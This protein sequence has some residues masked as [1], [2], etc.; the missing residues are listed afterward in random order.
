MLTT[1]ASSRSSEETD[2][3]QNT[4]HRRNRRLR[5]ATVTAL[6]MVGLWA[7]VAPAEAAPHGIGAG[8]NKPKYN[9]WQVKWFYSCTDEGNFKADKA[10]IVMF[11][12]GG[13]RVKGFHFKYRIVP[14]D[15]EGQPIPWA[16]WSANTA[17]SFDQGT[18]QTTWMTAGPQGQSWNPAADWDLEVKLKYP[19]SKRTAWRYKYRVAL[20]E[21]TCS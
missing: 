6:C 11:S 20:T 5:R 1:R 14:G 8:V 9:D 10:K 7:P 4:S 3:S 12:T 18:V 19:R 15:T 17:V 2:M 21:P 16:N 13:N